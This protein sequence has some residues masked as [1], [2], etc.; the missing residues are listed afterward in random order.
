MQL[1]TYAFRLPPHTCLSLFFFRSSGNK[2]GRLVPQASR[3]TSISMLIL[4][5]SMDVTLVSKEA[6][7]SLNPRYAVLVQTSDSE[8]R[9]CHSP[10]PL[11]GFLVAVRCYF[12]Q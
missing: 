8:Q 2:N 1:I 6:N 7:V 3:Y 5:I 11:S 4:K 10:Q 9:R 12:V